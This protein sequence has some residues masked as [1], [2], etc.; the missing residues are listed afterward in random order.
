MFE[1]KAHITRVVDGD[2]VDGIVDLGFKVGF[3]ARFRLE[4]INAPES[5]TRDLEEKKAGLASKEWLREAIEG[6]DVTVRTAKTG[7]FGRYLAT[8][9]TQDIIT[10]GSISINQQMLDNGHAMEYGQKWNTNHE[11]EQE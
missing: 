4:G 7:K 8:I 5:R 1:Y 3:N 2:T 9:F 11:S 6:K 10:P